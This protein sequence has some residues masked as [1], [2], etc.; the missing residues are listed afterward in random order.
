VSRVLNVG[1][2]SKEIPIPEHYSGWE[3]VLLDID[4]LRKPDVVCDAREL[5]TLPASLYDA[6]YCSHNLE[7]YWR[8]DVARVLKGFAHVLRAHG[9]AEIEVPDVKAVFADV[10]QRG[11]EPDGVL[12]ESAAAP[13][14]VNDVIY[15]HGRQI[16]ASGNDF[17]AHKNAFT[18]ASLG[19]A[20]RAAGFEWVFMGAGPYAIRALA[21][22]QAPTTDQR[23]LMRL[24]S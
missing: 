18:Q 10:L 13:I 2:G 16:A 6:V 22:R 5:A 11:L 20:Q 3:H 12:Y 8:H 14:T 24:P 23:S 7:H 1:G 15:G 21:F 4:A 17:Y 19:A 9:F